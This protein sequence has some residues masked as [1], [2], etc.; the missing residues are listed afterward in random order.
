MI[1]PQHLTLFWTKKHSLLALPWRQPYYVVLPLVYLT[2]ASFVTQ[3]GHH[4][5]LLY[6]KY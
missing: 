1:E 2:L 4:C 5:V 6:W 3:D